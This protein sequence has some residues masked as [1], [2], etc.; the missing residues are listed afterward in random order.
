MK[1]RI[2]T[3]LFILGLFLVSTSFAGELPATS[4]LARAEVTKM[5]KKEVRYPKFA[6]DEKFECCVLVSIVILHDGTLKV[7]CANCID[8]RMKEYVVNAIE[9][10]DFVKLKD[11][12][13]QTVQL[14]IRF[15]IIKT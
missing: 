8:H 5:I 7:G 1:T 12:A 11:F 4:K 6:I 3:V 15:K 13:G 10:A 14:R 9:D 2:A